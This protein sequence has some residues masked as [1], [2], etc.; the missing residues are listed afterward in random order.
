MLD[1][2]ADVFNNTVTFLINWAALVTNCLYYV[3]DSHLAK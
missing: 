3:A 1:D 2:D